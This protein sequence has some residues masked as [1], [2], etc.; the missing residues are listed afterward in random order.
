[1]FT[2]MLAHHLKNWGPRFLHI[3]NMCLI[4]QQ[5]SCVAARKLFNAVVALYGLKFANTI[6]YSSKHIGTYCT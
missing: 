4:I 6:H 3:M 1:M 5:E 2:E